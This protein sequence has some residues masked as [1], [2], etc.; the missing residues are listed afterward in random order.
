MSSSTRDRTL[1]VLEVVKAPDG[2][3]RYIDQ[4]VTFADPTVEFSFISLRNMLFGRY[5]VAHFHWPEMV[6]RSRRT[7]VERLK[8]FAFDTWVRVLARRGTAIVRTMHNERPHEDESA[9]VM[10]SLRRLDAA[11]DL[12]VVINTT[13]SRPAGAHYIPHGH[14]RDRFA[15]HRRQN[16]VPGRL[17]YAGLIRP[18]KGVDVLLR[19]FAE[20]PGDDLHLRVVGKPTA[21]LRDVVETAEASSRGRIS[22]RLEFVPDEDFV[23]EVSAAE[24]VCLPY[25]DLHNSGILLVA[26]SLD[27]PVLVP[28]TPSTRALADEV[29][30]G[31]VMT[32]EGELDGA[33]IR[34]ALVEARAAERAERP[35]M[36][37]RDWE[38]VG[39]LY[40][41]A[42]RAARRRARE[43]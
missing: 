32:F 4:V 25:R 41:E 34:R 37:D 3:T 43:C 12:Y 42:F 14:Y 2:S 15:P 27:R 11:T 28:A 22:A 30:P 5:D 10:R 9:A 23:A 7:I 16:V 20:C 31:W 8:C 33:A 29:G 26:L 6:V 36:Q 18:Y 13:G 21:A 40:S 38:N 1:R 39:R 24:L 19:A 35:H 17:I